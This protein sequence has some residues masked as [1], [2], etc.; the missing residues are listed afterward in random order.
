MIYVLHGE[1]DL[2]RAEE[3]KVLRDKWSDK[4]LGDL[5]TVV[6]DGKQLTIGKLRHHCDA[7]PF[8]SDSRVVIVENLL[9]RFEPRRGDKDSQEETESN[10]AL[11]QEW[12]DYMP[13]VPVTT[14]LVF[15]ESGAL[16]KNNAALKFLEGAKKN[17]VV[18][19]F[20]PPNERGLPDWI[21]K[22]VEGKGGQIEYS[23]A[24]ELA[25]YV[26][27]DLRAVDNEI[28]KLLAYRPGD[29][30]RREDVQALVAPIHEQTIFELVDALGKRQTDH[31]LKLLHEQL[32]H[33]AAPPYL[34][35]M[36]TRQF[37]LLLQI[38]DLQMRGLSD[39]LAEK[40]KL[41]PYYAR[42]LSDQAQNF[43]VEQLEM[44]Y[45]KLLEVD[46]AMKTSRGDPEVALDVLT[47]E[48]TRR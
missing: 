6:L 8:L 27:N 13:R 7:I 38:R 43:S 22:R 14:N 18:K 40:L 26:G 29:K 39:S 16:A 28:E 37:R 19:K 36:I 4:Q 32:A 42:K 2:L 30:I 45:H 3:L 10:P 35:A 41:N 47:V 25:L 24:N 34:M 9:S 48:L 17:A 46:V 20:D 5:N 11:K 21:L 23:A 33:N 12:L 1:A 15:I 44:I 31:A